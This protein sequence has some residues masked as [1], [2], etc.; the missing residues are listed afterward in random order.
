MNDL[1]ILVWPLINEKLEDWD[2]PT[3]LK[4][5]NLGSV[6]LGALPTELPDTDTVYWAVSSSARVFLSTL[7]LKVTSAAMAKL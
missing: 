5:T 7:A 1:E 4:F 2:V 3:T 6:G